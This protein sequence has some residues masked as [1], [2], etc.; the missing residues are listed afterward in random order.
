MVNR[1]TP[2]GYKVENGQ[3]AII[4]ERAT[5]V[6]RIY[7][8]FLSG[9]SCEKMANALNADNIQYDGKIPVW[10]KDKISRLLKNS[11]YIGERDFPIIIDAETFQAAQQVLRSKSTGIARYERN[12]SSIRPYL[13]CLYCGAVLRK[14]RDK[15][16]PSNSVKY[17]SCN[18]CGVQLT[19][20]DDEL[21]TEVERRI[22][23]HYESAG[24]PE[25]RQSDTS[26][27]LT[28]AI[29]RGLEKPDDPDKVIDLIL[30]GVS[31]RYNCWPSTPD[32]N[33]DNYRSE[34]R[35]WKNIWRAITDITVARSGKI[36][37]HFKD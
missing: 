11:C 31:A 6:K 28:N 32:L 8:D 1:W 20:S 26:V 34:E 30:Q 14:S 13:H 4:T 2:Y 33:P 16:N 27:R 15:Q 12:I 25:Y 9:D 17:L 18:K 3:L 7:Q 36:T 22:H 5:V 24:T 19:M 29:N 21:V 35:V 23:E 37:I 10:D